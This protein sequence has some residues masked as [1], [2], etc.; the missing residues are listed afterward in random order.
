MNNVNF[1]TEENI[2]SIHNMPKHLTSTFVSLPTSPHCARLH[3]VLCK[4]STLGHFVSLPVVWMLVNSN[5]NRSCIFANSCK[6]KLLWALAPEWQ[7]GS[8]NFNGHVPKYCGHSGK[9]CVLI[10]FYIKKETMKEA[11]YDDI[12]RNNVKVTNGY[13]ENLHVQ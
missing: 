7:V 9:G 10:T 4:V 6:E 5:S 12:A 11:S 2:P 1:T 8:V 3:V 13:F